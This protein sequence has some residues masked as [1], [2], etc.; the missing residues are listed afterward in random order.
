MLLVADAGELEQLRGVDGAAA[1]D[2][3]AGGHAA[4]PAGA[5][6]VDADGALA[7]E[8]DA[9]AER[10]RLDGQVLAVAHGVQV[11]PRGREAAAAV[12]VAVEAGEALLA[13]AVDVVGEVVARLLHG[14][15]ERAEERVGGRA[16]LE[17]ER[18]VAA[19]PL[20]R[21]D[22][23]V[24]E[25]AGLHPLEVGQAVGV[26]PLLHARLGRPALVVQRVAALE[27]HPVDARR[28]AE[29]LAAGVEH[30]AAVHV[31]LGVGPVLPVV[32]PVADR[33]RQRRR[34]VHERVDPPVGVAGLEHQHA[35]AGVG[36][37]AVGERAAGRATT[38]DDDVVP[39]CAHLPPIPV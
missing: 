31:G 13:V 35:G 32:E 30:P 39:V 26:A 4:R 20:V 34:H 28:A 10:E 9:G 25:E 38:D 33:D 11:G 29:H 17:H 19:T 23:A 36:G 2:H 12:H 24:D 8:P 22:G 37:D 14:L 6:V 21:G 7:L 3:L 18:A 27:D 1:Q 5:E 15:E 16:L